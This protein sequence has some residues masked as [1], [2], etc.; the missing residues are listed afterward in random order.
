MNS[1]E[2]ITQ[3]R[4]KKILFVVRSFSQSG[5]QPLRF[6][7]ILNFLKEEFNI[8]VLEIHHYKDDTYFENGLWLHKIKYSL[9]G[10]F[11]NFN[12]S[13]KKTKETNKTHDEIK[14]TLFFKSKLK[15]SVRKLFFPDILIFEK[16]RLIKKAIQLISI[17]KFQIIVSSGFPFTTMALSKEIKDKYP[18]VRFVYDIG[19]PF[20][21]N[22]NNGFIRNI[23]A[24]YYENKYL[25]YIDNLVVTNNMTLQHYLNNF[26]DK[27]K[28][29]QIEI[30]QMGVNLEY[31]KEVEKNLFSINETT[32]HKEV[33]LVYA[34]QLYKSLREP[35]EL[36]KAV[37]KWNNS[38][39]S[40]KIN[41]F[42]YGSFRDTYK[43]K[44]SS[45]NN[46]YFKGLVSNE[47]IIIAYYTSDVIVFIDNAWGMQTPGK[48]FEVSVIGKPV[49]F[50]SNN[51]ESPAFE[52][53]KNF[54]HFY[55]C[56]NNHEEII[57]T[58]KAIKKNIDI[59]LIKKIRNDFSWG[60]RA[61]KYSALLNK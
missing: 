12:E 29:D 7:M 47:E 35:F 25:K 44:D 15:R 32:S 42:M 37:A 59:S 56:T 41:L 5:A 51:K 45:L 60:N 17:Y 8:H 16:R 21:R 20:F 3:N 55:F 26:G 30:I 13:I 27:I 34:G 22:S 10:K 1:K 52:V 48:I 14:S 2:V 4:R 23:F 33:N 49:L 31:L 54:K 43:I 11:L 57:S 36:Y 19:D 40:R 18:F 6:K 9:P 58:I 24:G 38:T 46:I 53:V 39:E 61:K 50:I 28:Q